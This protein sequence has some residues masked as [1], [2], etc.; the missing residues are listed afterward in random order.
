LAKGKSSITIIIIVIAVVLAAIAGVVIY[1]LNSDN[2][3]TRTM[4]TISKDG[5][6]AAEISDVEYNYKLVNIM[7]Q[8]Q[9]SYGLTD[10][11]EIKEFWMTT[12][13]GATQLDQI[14]S[15][16]LKQ[17]EYSKVEYLK[18]IDSGI[19]LTDAEQKDLN[20]SFDNLEQ[21]F[22]DAD[23]DLNDYLVEKYGISFK[24]YK[25]MSRENKI[26]NKFST[27]QIASIEVTDDE[28]LAY[29]NENIDDYYTVTIRHILLVKTDEDGNALDEDAL[30]D[31]L[32]LANGLLDK[33]NNGED[34]DALVAE[35]SEDPNVSDNDGYYDVT[36]NSGYDDVFQDWV[37]NSEVGDTAVIE[38]DYGYH[39]IKTYAISTYDD[40]K[41][42]IKSDLQTSRYSET[43]S[44][45]WAK[46]YDIEVYD[47]I[48]ESI[49][50][51]S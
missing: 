51:L 2:I 47:S 38:T 50:P 36:A 35:Y 15:F 3:N 45:V 37:M 9:T 6:A 43:L 28:V 44:N 19:G 8:L 17:A 41:D 16:A 31:K 22:K 42:K 1:Y 29:Y 12:Y 34:M 4:V 48:Y 14:K 26:A 21:Q 32:T 39:V 27:A 49:D 10:E 5:E 25:Q 7:L 46:E 40:M 11:A 24:M 23:L 18:A 13:E 30:A 20:T 33:I